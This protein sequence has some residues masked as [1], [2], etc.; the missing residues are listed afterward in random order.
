MGSCESALP[1]DKTQAGGPMQFGKTGNHLKC[2][3]N[4]VIIAGYK[5]MSD[6]VIPI[7]DHGMFITALPNDIALLAPIEKTPPPLF[8]FNRTQY[9]AK[10]MRVVD[11]DT[12]VIAV[13]HRVAGTLTPVSFKCRALGYNVAE[14]RRYKGITDAELEKGKT[15]KEYV[16]WLIEGKIIRVVFFNTDKYGR[17]LIE[18][19]FD[20]AKS[21]ERYNVSLADHL[22]G[23]GHAAAYS[24]SGE[25]NW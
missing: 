16:T 6:I 5:Q 17:P 8:D 21:T 23:I 13:I 7:G 25:K 4:D 19:S 12:F 9:F 3:S 14:S 20:D 11:G 22:I 24:G 15:V 10:C 1:D 2:V 18:V